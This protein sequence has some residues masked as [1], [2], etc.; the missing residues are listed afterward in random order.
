[1][2]LILA[3]SDGYVCCP[4]H[5]LGGSEGGDRGGGV[6]PRSLLASTAASTHAS[7]VPQETYHYCGGQVK[8]GG[9][10]GLC[11]THHLHS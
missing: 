4:S 2:R 1:M 9:G 3:I 6:F 7:T 10:V 8:M 11:L 5:Y